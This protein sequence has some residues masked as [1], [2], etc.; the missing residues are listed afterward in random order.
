MEKSNTLLEVRNLTK[1][2]SVGSIFRKKN[3][4]AVDNVSFHI[5]SEKSLIFGIIGE[6]GS[7][8]TTIARLILGFIKKTSGEI[9]FKGRDIGSFRGKGWKNYYREAQAV[10]QDPFS[11]LNPL[12]SV[13]RVLKMPIRKFN[14]VQSDSEMQE[15]VS[16]SL[17]VVGLD[18]K[19]ISGKHPDQLSGGERQRVMLARTFLIRPKLII[20]DEPTSMLDASLKADILNIIRDLKE[21]WNISFIYITHNISEIYYVSDMLMAMYLGSPVELGSTSEI[22]EKPLHPYVQMLMSSVPIPDP[23]YKWKERITLP[24]IEITRRIE[25]AKGCKF[26]DRCPKRMELCRKGPPSMTKVSK[27]HEVACLLHVS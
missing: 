25:L 13:D 6:S 23:A 19:N 27:E 3:L 7:G 22:V 10:F 5:P 15:L 16:E 14:L 2:F 11:A 8:K 26:Y 4:V 1:V 18:I 24:A 12:Y 21:K 20:A 9:L 17:K